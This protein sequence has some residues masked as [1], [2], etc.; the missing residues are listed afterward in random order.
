[1]DNMNATTVIRQGLLPCPVSVLSHQRMIY[2][3]ITP[4][5]DVM[6]VINR[7]L[8]II[9][10][11]LIST[12]LICTPAWADD[13]EIYF[14]GSNSS[15]IK[16]NVMFILDTSGSMGSKDG[17]NISRMDRMKQALTNVLNNAE[18]INVGLMRFTNPGGPVLYPAR[19]I[20]QA[21]TGDTTNSLITGNVDVRIGSGNNDAEE[22]SDGTVRLNSTLLEIL[23]PGSATISRTVSHS[24]DDAEQPLGS[25]AKLDS[26][27]LEMLYEG[28]TEQ[29]IGVRFRLVDIPQGTH[30]SNAYLSFS[31]KNHYDGDLSVR[32]FGED[33]DNARVFR[34]KKNNLTKRNQT[35]ASVDW[36]IADADAPTSGQQMQSVNISTI[37][38]EIVNRD[39][40]VANNK[41]AFIIERI[42]GSSSDKRQF[43]SFDST[44][45]SDLRPQLHID[46]SAASGSG[47]MQTVGLRFNDVSVPQGATITSARLKLSAGDSNAESASLTFWGELAGHSDPFDVSVHNL[48]GRTPTTNSVGWIG[49]PAWSYG[50]TYTAPELLTIA[51]EIVDLSVWCGGNSM[52]FFVKG[53]AQR[54]MQAFENDV[55]KAPEL[56]ISYDIDTVAEGACIYQPYS[57]N[58][59]A[60]SDDAEQD[61]STMQLSSSDLDLGE[62]TVGLRYSSIPL[63][64]DTT[65]SNAYIEFTAD[66][67]NSGATS[68]TI[69]GHLNANPTTFTTGS[70]NISN[71][72]LTSAAAS[73]TPETWNQSG[74]TLQSPNIA[75]IINELTAQNGWASGNAMAFIIEGS[76]QRRSESYDSSNLAPRLVLYAKPNDVT[77]TSGTVR[78]EMI[79]AV[80]S[81][82]NDGWTPIVD[83]LYE[84][85]RYYRGEPVEYGRNRGTGGNKQLK[86]ISH[87]ESYAGGLVVYPDGCTAE[88]PGASDCA[89]ESLIDAADSV[90]TYITPITED[91]QANY[92]VLLTD[93]LANHNNSIQ[94]IKDMTGAT[95]CIGNDSD[96]TCGIELIDFLHTQDQLSRAQD[97]IIKTYTIGLEFETDWLTSLAETGGGSFFQAESASDLTSAFDT[98]IK[99]IKAVNTTFVQPSV[100]INQFNRFSHRDDVYFSLFKPQETSKWYGNLK[101]YQLK[102]SP[103]TLYDNRSPQQPAID[104]LTGF[105]GIDSRSFWSV[106]EDGNAVE[107]GGAASK[108]PVTRNL[109]TNV[110]GAELSISDNALH[111]SNPLI[112]KDSALLDI[113]AKSDAYRDDLLKWARGLDANGAQRLELGD[114]LHSRPELVTYNGLSDPPAS[115]IFVGTNEGFL[116]AVDINTGIEQFAFIP[117]ELL[118]NLDTYYV[119]ASTPSR[120]YGLDGGITLWTQDVSKDGD[121]QDTGDFAY[122][123]IGMR[124]GG[125]NYYALDVTDINNPRLMWQITGGSPGFEALGQT[126][127][128]PVKSKVIFDNVKYDVLI[129][130]GGYDPSQDDVSVRTADAVGNAVYIVDAVTGALIWSAGNNNSHN[131]SHADMDYGIPSQIRV[132][133]INQDGIADQL[134][135]GDMGGQLWRFDIYN[136]DNDNQLNQSVDMTRLA[137]LGGSTA[138]DNR[139]FYYPPDLALAVDG[140]Q[141]YLSLAIGSGFRAHPLNTSIDDRFYMIKQFATHA[142]PVGWTTLTEA[143]LYDA[144]DNHI[145]GSDATLQ[146]SAEIALSNSDIDRKEGWYLRMQDSGEKVLSGST[147]I[148]NQIVFTSYAPTAATEGSCNPTQGTSRAYLVSLFD[149]T[150]LK[151]INEDGSITAADRVIQLQIGSIPATP[152]VIDTL[153][154]K[155]TVWVGPERLDQ[156][157]TDVESARTYW[158]EESY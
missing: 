48:S 33:T 102:G 128:Q 53:N 59:L 37:V 20:D 144:T 23:N 39:G 21:L 110:S 27:D 94:K 135:V 88:N 32:I 113:A 119:N 38:Q 30:I 90:P 51:Q 78:S 43:H 74:D 145:G 44:T 47:E 134:Y 84:A 153:D 107:K 95:S 79:A 36:D 91:C 98:I 93:G 7:K 150:P 147:T 40:W 62:K 129:F 5:G 9:L 85:A 31:V 49:T 2:S 151:D 14:G 156:V 67:A 83:T 154:S 101:K 8:R 71:R 73:W 122:L 61:R 118:R 148:Q 92:I 140:K 123:Y 17:G 66:A 11:S 157:D 111:E 70:N 116:H 29:V 12:W 46:Y 3:G 25:K 109:Y 50:S 136:T 125:R 99:T 104:P 58:I 146:A 60:G 69:R 22:L 131:E 55:D 64:A 133:D 130:G 124:R 52:T 115:S 56:E 77:A 100:T 4:A 63:A 15:T 117:Q 68:L 10:S 97:Q 108:I 103:A 114:P 132:I 82:P 155:P 65:L 75:S 57:Y 120:P 41:M 45:D 35:T 19:D 72:T 141:R 24:N 42:S 18:D 112:S 137:N 89:G 86:R 96:E 26:T 80:Q 106:D 138:A 143:D 6:T 87:T 16:P 142:K 126:W 152:T 28:N 121:L 139:R 1:M 127:S 34:N 105:F 149:A 54:I 81:L 76:G 158:I 13:T